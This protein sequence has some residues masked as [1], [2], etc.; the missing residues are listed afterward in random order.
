M[1]FGPLPGG[2]Q[3]NVSGVDP[4]RK[5]L[6]IIFVAVAVFLS[7]IV[8]FS[9]LSSRKDPAQQSLIS[10]AVAEN[11]MLRMS[12]KNE[13]QISSSVLKNHNADLKE[14]LTTNS[15]LVLAELKRVYK[16]KAVPAAKQKAAIDTKTDTSLA[17]SAKLNRFDQDYAQK[18]SDN[19]AK[20]IQYA[21]QAQ[22]QTKNSKTK[23]VLTTVANTTTELRNRFISDVNAA[24]SQT[25]QP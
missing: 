3:T 16:V 6:A 1:G 19:L 18:V 2:Y 22:N 14:G 25:P 20:Q 5:R 4:R 9:I 23:T 11:E 24:S 8:V 10:L 15:Q 7:L 17:N 21:Q 12:K 13:T